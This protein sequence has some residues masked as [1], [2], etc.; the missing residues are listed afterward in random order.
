MSVKQSKL[1]LFLN[2]DF[3]HLPHP[4]LLGPTHFLIVFLEYPAYLLNQVHLG[5]LLIFPFDPLLLLFSHLDDS[6]LLHILTLLYSLSLKFLVY[7]IKHVDSSTESL[8]T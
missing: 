6:I 8:V 1:I 3:G 4:S 5:L 2:F 7:F